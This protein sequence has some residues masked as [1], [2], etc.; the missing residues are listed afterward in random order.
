M[1]NRNWYEQLVPLIEKV[2][3]LLRIICVAVIMLGAYIALRIKG[4]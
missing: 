3:D 1:K 2:I 4:I